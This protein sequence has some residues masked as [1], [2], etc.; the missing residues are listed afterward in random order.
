MHTRD[1]W[2]YGLSEST[3]VIENLSTFRNKTVQI[4]RRTRIR[5]R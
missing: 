3:K 4:P 2:F 1:R 5:N